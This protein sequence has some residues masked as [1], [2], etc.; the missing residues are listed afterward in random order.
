MLSD[1]SKWKIKDD[2]SIDTSEGDNI[3][4][5]F[6]FQDKKWRK[7]HTLIPKIL[8]DEQRKQYI[9]E[10]QK[11]LG[12][13]EE[14][15][16]REIANE[17][18]YYFDNNKNISIAD[19]ITYIQDKENIKDKVNEIVNEA[20]NDEV[21]IEEMNEYID[22]VLKVATKNEI[23]RLKEEMKKELDVDKKMKIAMQ[24]AELK[25]EDV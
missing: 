22:V 12:F 20:M 1:I 13:F 3:L 14:P 18:L 6:Y 4:N 21:T 11:R 8:T 25:K 15:V 9:K 24:I 5:E 2:G 17:I 10:Y 23:K 7:E 16:Y 19:F